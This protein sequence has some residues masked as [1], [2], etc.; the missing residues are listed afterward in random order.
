MR[1][2]VNSAGHSF[3]PVAGVNPE[4][5]RYRGKQLQ[6]SDLQKF[7]LDRFTQLND[8]PVDVLK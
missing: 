5:L 4:T 8:K 6:V 2:D 7:N 1:S 3:L